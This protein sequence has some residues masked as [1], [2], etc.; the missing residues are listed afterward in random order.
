MSK[1]QVMSH[2][3]SEKTITHFIK[4]RKTDKGEDYDV[5]EIADD[6]TIFLH[7]DQTKG[8][9]AALKQFEEGDHHDII[10]AVDIPVKEDPMPF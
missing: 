3:N 7:P 2:L 4:R 9:L 1:I 6:V 8:L 10:V 5:L